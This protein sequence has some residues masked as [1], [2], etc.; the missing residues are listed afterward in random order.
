[1][2]VYMCVRMCMCVFDASSQLMRRRGRLP[3]LVRVRRERE[4]IEAVGGTAH[5]NLGQRARRS[6]HDIGPAL[7][8]L[9]PQ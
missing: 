1:M 7:L 9:D 4:A 5:H 2:Y 3:H 8:L 6:V